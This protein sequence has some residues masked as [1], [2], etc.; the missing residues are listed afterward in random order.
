M[1]RRRVPSAKNLSQVVALVHALAL[2]GLLVLP[3][4]GLAWATTPADFG[5][6]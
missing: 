2:F 1:S 5:T 3:L 6:A 4:V